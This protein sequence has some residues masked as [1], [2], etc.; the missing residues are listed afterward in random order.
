MDTFIPLHNTLSNMRHKQTKK[1]TSKQPRVTFVP[2]HNTLSTLMCVH[3]N[4]YTHG[5][6]DSYSWW[7]LNPGHWCHGTLSPTLYQLSHPVILNNHNNNNNNTNNN[8]NLQCALMFNA[9]STTG[10]RASCMGFPKHS[11]TI[12][13]LDSSQ[14]DEEN[15][16]FIGVTQGKEVSWCTWLLFVV[17]Q[18]KSKITVLSLPLSILWARIV[19]F[20]LALLFAWNADQKIQMKKNPT[21]LNAWRV[22]KSSTP[23]WRVSCGYNRQARQAQRCIIIYIVLL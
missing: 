14:S 19:F 4:L 18:T 7:D 2:L 16:L 12:H 22:F 5:H 20:I 10:I 8:G 15:L 17:W 21:N 6:T 9:K 13:E 1:Q 11:D 23:P 3:Y